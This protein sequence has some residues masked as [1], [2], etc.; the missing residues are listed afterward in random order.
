[1]VTYDYS[2][3]SEQLDES[4]E[5]LIAAAGGSPDADLVRE[6]MV[7]A[8]KLITDN[9]ERVDLKILNSAFKELRYSFKI[10]QEYRNISKVSIFGSARTKEN[11]PGYIQAELFSKEIAKKGWMVITGAGPGIM[12]AATEGAGRE[13]AFGV[14]IRLPFEQK[15]NVEISGDKKLINFKYFFT[16]KLFF[17]REAKAI[18]LL[19]GGFGTLDEGYETLTLLQTGK[20]E[21][22]PIVLLEGEGS[23]YWTK[24]VEFFHDEV[25]PRGL[26]S[27]QD[28]DFFFK[29]KKV[30]EAVE[31]VVGFYYNYHSLRYVRDLLVIRLKKL[32]KK[33]L[34]R[35]NSEFSDLLKKG[36]F[37]SSEALPEEANEP[38]L[39]SKQ[40]IIFKF[41]RCSF[42][43]L[44]VFINMLNEEA[45]LDKD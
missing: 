39:V 40:R 18:V 41:N 9:A 32:T 26:I 24:W 4:I 42:A 17:V 34:K 22:K 15:P 7:T 25:I 2:T 37:Q 10:F 20:S 44:R 5:G 19:P 30:K 38:Q 28:V 13:K 12:K 1:M 31:E 29:T 45:D 21:P 16:R 6:I 8:I 27:S 35:A 33:M 36:D 23:D 3:G 43:R 14:N 11:D